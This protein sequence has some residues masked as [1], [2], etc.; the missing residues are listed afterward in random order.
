MQKKEIQMIVTD[1]CM[2]P[3]HNNNGYILF[4]QNPKVQVNKIR[5]NGHYSP[6]IPDWCPLEDAQ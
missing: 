3:F 1:C 2:C 5:M 6:K 4:C